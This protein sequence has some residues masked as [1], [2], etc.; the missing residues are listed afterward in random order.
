MKKKGKKSIFEAFG[1]C[2]GRTHGIVGIIGK[3]TT[4]TRMNHL[5]AHAHD[6]LITSEERAGLTKL[7][8][9]LIESLGYLLSSVST[10]NIPSI[11]SFRLVQDKPADF[12]S[13]RFISAE[14]QE[15]KIIIFFR[16]P[17]S[18]LPLT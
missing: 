3:K 17:E 10:P 12:D 1:K 6:R 9:L 15:T 4:S 5:V 16:S 13:M 11:T 8:C 7:L 2:S 14:L 18:S